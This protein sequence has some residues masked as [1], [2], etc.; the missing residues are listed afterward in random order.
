MAAFNSFT[1]LGNLTAD[2]ELRYTPGGAPICTFSVAVNVKR[3]D[4][5]GRQV[6][7]VNFFRIT[8]KF[9][10]ADVCAK[11]LK[12]GRA[13]FVNGQLESWRN[14]A[15]FGMN[16]VAETVQFLGGSKAAVQDGGPE[17]VD[18]AGWDAEMIAW[19]N[20]LGDVPSVE[21]KFTSANTPQ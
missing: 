15:R 21:A 8:A 12:K 11:Y 10:L 5:E 13:V 4:A 20:E 16:F 7:H 2:P 6:D 1:I 3:K 9:K 18:Q 19:A 17:G 14:E